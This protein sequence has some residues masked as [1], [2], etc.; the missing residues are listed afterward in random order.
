MALLG[1]LLSGM[2]AGL[3]AGGG[4]LSP[5]VFEDNERRRLFE[6]QR[7]D[8][9]RSD[10]FKYVWSGMQ[11][12]GQIDL[13]MAGQIAQQLG[14]SGFGPSYQ[15]QVNML[16]AQQRAM[17]MQREEEESRRALE[18][19]NNPGGGTPV[20]G[21]L[22]GRVYA[23]H[24]PP[25][26]APL[27]IERLRALEQD[28]ITKGDRAAAADYRRQIA[29]SQ[30]MRPPSATTVTVNNAAEKKFQSKG[31]DLAAVAQDRAI[32]EGAAAQGTAQTLAQARELMAK[33]LQTSRPDAMLLGAQQMAE[34]LGLDINEVAAKAGIKLGPLTSKEE[35]SRL[36]STLTVQNMA[37]LGKGN[38]NQNEVNLFARAT[39]N[40]GRTTDANIDAIAAASAATE[41]AAVDAEDAAMATSAQEM[42]Q[43]QV[44]R[45]R[46]GTKQFLALKKKY[47]DE[48]RKAPAKAVETFADGS[49]MEPDGKGGFVFYPAGK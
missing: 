38:L 25:A 39:A 37:E 35:L 34:G 41:M 6:M 8:A 4:V 27:P 12:L 45:A 46:R 5:Q 28:A 31:G 23:T 33:G 20:P 47:A 24:N 30:Y 2:G 43:V 48:M 14:E 21:S 17:K 3:R 42:R 7:A 1:S 32:T 9:R 15:T 10:M 11:V 19:A 44:R 49:R 22:A 16:T 36:L 40:P 29:K 26:P 13:Q 18:Y